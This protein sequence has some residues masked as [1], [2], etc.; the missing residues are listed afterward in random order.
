MSDDLEERSKILLDEANQLFNHLEA[1]ISYLG[2][3][4]SALFGILLSLISLQVAL[5]ILVL[6]GGGNFSLFS[7]IL[8]CLFASVMI[9][10]VFL[11]VY[12]LKPCT[13]KDVGM[14]KE[15]RFKELCS[16][17]KLVLLSDLLYYVK[18]SYEN[19]YKIYNDRIQVLIYWYACFLVGNLLYILLI[20]SIG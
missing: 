5:M 13:Y 9:V 17:P 12:L 4:V 20:V 2:G 11:L 10:S 1:N 14:F 3:K 6:N 7:C 15:K 18:I 16:F 19:N 8:L